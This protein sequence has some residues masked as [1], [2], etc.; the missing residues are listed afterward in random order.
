MVEEIIAELQIMQNEGVY[1]FTKEM[2]REERLEI[3]A[4]QMTHF[5]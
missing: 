5:R 4:K 1:M 2:K 3:F